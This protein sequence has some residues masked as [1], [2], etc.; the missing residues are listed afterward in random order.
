MRRAGNWEAFWST[1][2][3]EIATSIRDETYEELRSDFDQAVQAAAA[4]YASLIDDLTTEARHT[5]IEESVR[6][7]HSI[8]LY[9]QPY[10]CPACHNHTLHGLYEV[11]RTVEVDDSDAPENI[12]YFVTETAELNFAHCPVCDLRLDRRFAGFTDVPLIRDHGDKNATPEEVETWNDGQ[13]E[14]HRF[15][16]EHADIDELDES[17]HP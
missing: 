7:A 4:R 15:A 6:R 11:H 10:R 16:Y 9:T 13:Y 3:A 8:D 17:N 12:G 5:R 1:T 2:Y 14:K